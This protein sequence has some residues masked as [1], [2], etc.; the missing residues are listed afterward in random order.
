MLCLGPPDI[1]LEGMKPCKTHVLHWWCSPYGSPPKSETWRIVGMGIWIME[2]PVYSI[3]C[4]ICQN[5]DG[6]N[7]CVPTMRAV[8]P[9]QVVHIESQNPLKGWDWHRNHQQVLADFN[10]TNFLLCK[11]AAKDQNKPKILA[12]LAWE[13]RVLSIHLARL[14]SQPHDR[15]SEDR[16]A[17]CSNPFSFSKACQP[18][19][20]TASSSRDDFLRFVLRNILRSLLYAR[21]NWYPRASKSAICKHLLPVAF[22]CNT[23][24]F[25]TLL[26]QCGQNRLC[27][28][29]L[30]SFYCITAFTLS[31]ATTPQL[32]YHTQPY[33]EN[34]HS[35]WGITSPHQPPFKSVQ[36]QL[37]VNKAAGAETTGE[38]VGRKII[39]L[40][41]KACLSLAQPHHSIPNINI[42]GTQTRLFAGISICISS[43]LQG[44]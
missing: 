18:T 11:F 40:L 20:P 23:W 27:S 19:F 7:R 26:W 34:Q 14:V 21:R 24:S 44:V 13:Y 1:L 32:Y 6:V 12:S 29:L 31:W 35:I 8:D 5:S 41:H 39:V 3:R 38:N 10:T 30:L 28:V 36:V 15:C 16:L 17:V 22:F 37:E 2:F 33:L 4:Q 42:L 43:C 25:W 9:H